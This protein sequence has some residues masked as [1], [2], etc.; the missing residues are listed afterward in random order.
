MLLLLPPLWIRPTACSSFI[1]PSISRLT[2]NSLS[3]LFAFQYFLWH[4]LFWY[5]SYPE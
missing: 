4:I 3:F 5:Y 2:N 1:H